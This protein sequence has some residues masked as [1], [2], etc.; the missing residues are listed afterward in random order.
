MKKASAHCKI[1]CVT[2]QRKRTA[3]GARR[4]STKTIFLPEPDRGL[5][6]GLG[7]ELELGIGLN[8]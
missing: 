6:L 8:L 4:T 1:L 2:N 7:L 3:I 5:G